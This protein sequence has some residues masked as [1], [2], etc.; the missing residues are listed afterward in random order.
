M[1]SIPTLRGVQW[2]LF[3]SQTKPNE[4]HTLSSKRPSHRKENPSKKQ[5]YLKTEIL[6]LPVKEYPS[7]RH[8]GL[9]VSD[10][11]ISAKEQTET[12]RDGKNQDTIV[13]SF[14]ELW[15][16]SWSSIDPAHPLFQIL[17]NPVYM[18]SKFT[19][20][21]YSIYRTE[22]YFYDKRFHI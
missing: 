8:K 1:E 21:Q 19:F 2:K 20:I 10:V 5:K 18:H 16:L 17:S 15:C 6:S 14:Q 4:R 3:L 13:S 12:K 7:M 11:H 22:R 9:R